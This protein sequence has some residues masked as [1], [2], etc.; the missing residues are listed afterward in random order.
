MVHI[1]P[2]RAIQPAIWRAKAFVQSKNSHPTIQ[3][4]IH[5]SLAMF[6][7]DARPGKCSGRQGRGFRNLSSCLQ[8][9]HVSKH[10][11][12][13]AYDDGVPQGSGMGV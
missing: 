12:K 2:T 5:C 10:W 3:A 13:W 8:V 1:T 7:P 11:I 9:K 4:L 6:L